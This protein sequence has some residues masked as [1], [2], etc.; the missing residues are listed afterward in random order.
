MSLKPST[1]SSPMTDFD[2]PKTD[3]FDNVAYSDIVEGSVYYEEEVRPIII[4]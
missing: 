4:N 1:P 2:I 3:P